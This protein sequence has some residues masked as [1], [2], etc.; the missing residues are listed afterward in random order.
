MVWGTTRA[1]QGID[2]EREPEQR[3]RRDRDALCMILTSD[4]GCGTIRCGIGIR[5]AM[6]TAWMPEAWIQIL[7]HEQGLGPWRTLPCQMGRRDR[8]EGGSG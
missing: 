6:V 8:Q 4:C 2:R 3:G 5:Q 1:S 7:K